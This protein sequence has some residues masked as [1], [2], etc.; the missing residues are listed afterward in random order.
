MATYNVEAW[1]SHQ[2]KYYKKGDKIKAE[3]LSKK[4]QSQLV[5]KG[6]ISRAADYADLNVVIDD[7]KAVDDVPPG[8]DEPIEKTLDLN[9]EWDELKD[10]AKSIG[11]EWK[12]N[13]SKENL[14]KLIIESDKQTHFLDQLE[15]GEENGI[16]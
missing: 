2:G 16:I 10:E 5:K 14:I 9:F 8:E 7:E 3:L 1:L 15:D 13:I 11:L 6:V 4:Q 12:G